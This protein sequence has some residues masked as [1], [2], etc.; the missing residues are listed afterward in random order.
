MFLHYIRAEPD[1]AGKWKGAGKNAVKGAVRTERTRGAE[2]AIGRGAAP[3]VSPSQK[4][5]AGATGPPCQLETAVSL[6][7]SEVIPPLPPT[8][9]C[10]CLLEIKEGG[11]GSSPK[12]SG[13][14]ALGQAFKAAAIPRWVLCETR[15]VWEVT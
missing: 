7:L 12:L 2:V 1:E 6:H 13:A 5:V 4:D 10:G 8:S 15:P 9:T 14:S 3:G 11:S